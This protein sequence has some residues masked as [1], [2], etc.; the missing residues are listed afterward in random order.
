M[1]FIHGGNF[2]FSD[3][4]I[5]IY[6][7]ERLVNDTN[8]VVALIQYRLGKCMNKN[9]CIRSKEEEEEEKENFLQ[10]NDHIKDRKMNN[11]MIFS[12]FFRTF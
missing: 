7:A 1:L 5:G 6:E 3:A 4:S 8:I 12:I 10:E 11:D 2:Q 9:F